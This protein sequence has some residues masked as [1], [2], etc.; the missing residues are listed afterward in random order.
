M[1]ARGLHRRGAALRRRQDHGD[2]RAAR[3]A[4]RAAAFA[5]ARRKRDRTTSIRPSML[6]SRARR[7][8]ISI[9]GRC[10]ATCSM[11]WPRKPRA[12]PTRGDRRRHGP[13][14]RRRRAGRPARRDRR[15]RRAFRPAGRARARRGGAGAVGGGGRARL[16]RARSRPCALPASSST[17]SRSERHRTLRRRRDRRARHS[18][19][20]RP[21]ARCRRSRCR[22]GISASCRPREHPDL[23]RADRASCRHRRAPYRPRR[24]SSAHAGPFKFAA[25]IDRRRGAAAARPAH[26]ARAATAPSASSIRTCS[27]PGARPAPKSCRSRRSPTSRRRRKPT[28]AGCPAAI[29]SCT[30]R[31]S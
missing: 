30:R 8:S 27:R 3:G 26:R 15:S 28:A 20:R 2:A 1:T 10:R 5:C 22:S 6:R 23:A 9:A 4:A 24:A 11:R 16:C 31:P 14:R 29:R 25:A 21:A 18:R 13:V 17:A 19:A 12:T 7:A